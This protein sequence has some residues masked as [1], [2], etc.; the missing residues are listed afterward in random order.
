MR[1][2][3]RREPEAIGLIEAIVRRLRG[4]GG[5]G[6]D[7]GGLREV[8]EDL[9]EDQDDEERLG[10]DARELVRNAL[11][12]AD[13]RV[14]DVMVPRAD[15]KG[16][17]VDASLP[18]VVAALRSAG[19]SR[20]VVYRGSLDDVLGVVSVRDLLPFWGD[21][22]EFQLERVMRPILIVP[23]SM[24]VL[25]LLIE[26][27]AKH[28]QMAV[29]VDEFGGTDGL[30]TLEDMVEEIVGEL[31]DEQDILKEPQIVENADG[32][33]DADARVYLDDLEERLGLALLED[34]ERDEIDTLGGLIFNLLDRVPA[35]GEVVAHPSGIELEVL[36]A[37]PRRIGRVRI[38]RSRR[39]EAGLDRRGR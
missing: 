25:D 10:E 6:D 13:L 9:I 3:P 17:P 26:M 1:A 34:E 16:V 4:L 8:L 23:P 32:T 12:F 14:D 19:H 5:R 36:E 7:S 24:R 39:V 31:S 21:G 15:I 38:H 28:S 37:D 30:V 2:S 11:S 18:E 29:V 20:L 22:G 33:L 27:R 35:K